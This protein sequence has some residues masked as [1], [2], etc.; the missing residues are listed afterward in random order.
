MERALQV[1]NCQMFLS[2][3]VYFERTVT[4]VV[5]VI[6]GGGAVTL[7]TN[8]IFTCSISLGYNNAVLAIFGNLF[9]AMVLSNLSITATCSESDAPIMSI[10]GLVSGKTGK[11]LSPL[12]TDFGASD[13]FSTSGPLCFQAAQLRTLE[14]VLF[15]YR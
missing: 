5:L 12:T 3:L 6:S 11:P 1:L 9:A 2:P 7:T 13:F 8:S 14:Q 15:Q 4:R 10:D